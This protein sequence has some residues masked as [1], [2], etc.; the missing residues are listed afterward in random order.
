MDALTW[1]VLAFV[2]LT[3]SGCVSRGHAACRAEIDTSGE[4]SGACCGKTGRSGTAKNRA[5]WESPEVRLL[6]SEN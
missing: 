1:P 4:I 2:M 5:T 3:L 6:C